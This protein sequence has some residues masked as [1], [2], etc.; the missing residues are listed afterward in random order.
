M[1]WG[2]AKFSTAEPIAMTPNHQQM[3]FNSLP[4]GAAIELYDR[5]TGQL[6][7]RG[8][9]P[10]ETRVPVGKYRATF[11]KPGYVDG[12]AKIPIDVGG[13]TAGRVISRE[14]QAE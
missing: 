14:L 1:A 12:A 8:T 2:K 13:S 6:A 7:V 5:E 3:T 9:T 4:S 11:I 10:F